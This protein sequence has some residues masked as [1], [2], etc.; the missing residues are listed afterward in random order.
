MNHLV[1]NFD[2]DSVSQKRRNGI[3]IIRNI[4]S[5]ETNTKEMRISLKDDYFNYTVLYLTP[6]IQNSLKPISWLLEDISN[7]TSVKEVLSQSLVTL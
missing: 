2:S 7:L 1:K 3:N 6:P 4:M 5:I